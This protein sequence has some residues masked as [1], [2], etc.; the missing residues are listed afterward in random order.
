[1]QKGDEGLLYRISSG[2]DRPCSLGQQFYSEEFRFDSK[3]KRNLPSR[4]YRLSFS[5]LLIVLLLLSFLT[6]FFPEILPNVDLHSFVSTYFRTERRLHFRQ[7]QQMMIIMAKSTTPAMTAT[8]MIQTL[9]LP[10]RENCSMKIFSPR[11]DPTRRFEHFPFER[12]ECRHR[13]KNENRSERWGV[14]FLYT[15]TRLIFQI[16][17]LARAIDC[18]RDVIQRTGFR[19]LTIRTIE[20]GQTSLTSASTQSR[21]IRVSTVSSR[22][23]PDAN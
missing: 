16:V 20:I 19:R 8:T 23:R 13:P 18:I 22:T 21:T 4:C 15:Y 5:V 6:T 14:C 11:L 10:K 1:M 7:R 17:D 12:T 3:S 2:V 9:K